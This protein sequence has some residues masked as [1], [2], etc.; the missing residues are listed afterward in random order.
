MNSNRRSG[1]DRSVKRRLNA[2]IS[3]YVHRR[4]VSRK[5]ILSRVIWFS[6]MYVFPPTTSLAAANWIVGRR[7]EAWT[8]CVMA[9]K[10]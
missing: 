4:S 10:A 7:Q 8:P 3:F 1:P 5:R 6:R 2:M 9:L